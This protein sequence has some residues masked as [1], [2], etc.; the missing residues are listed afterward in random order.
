MHRRPVPDPIQKPLFRGFFF[1]CIVQATCLQKHA[2]PTLRRNPV[3][4]TDDCTKRASDPAHLN[5]LTT[6]A[7]M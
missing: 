7:V 1:G 2:T 6:S 5:G 4:T 3:R